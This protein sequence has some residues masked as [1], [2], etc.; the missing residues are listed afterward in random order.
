M[1]FDWSQDGG[2]QLNL[3]KRRT[4]TEKTTFV[5]FSTY[6]YKPRHWNS[7][8]ELAKHTRLLVYLLLHRLRKI[9]STSLG[10]DT[11][12]MITSINVGGDTTNPITFYVLCLITFTESFNILCI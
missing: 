4:Q 5:F 9:A 11:Q 2:G 10:R 12:P 7:Y 1:F 3:A 6:E 8:V